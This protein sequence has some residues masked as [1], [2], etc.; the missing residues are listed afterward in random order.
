MQDDEDLV[1][2]AIQKDVDDD[3]RGVTMGWTS[4]RLKK[5][6]EFIAKAMP[7]TGI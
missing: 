1:L 2:E 6:R 5:D 7:V 4:D 3:Q